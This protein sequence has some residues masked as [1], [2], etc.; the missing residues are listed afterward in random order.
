MN[1]AKSP[2]RTL[3]LLR[4][5]KSSW[6]DPALTD[7]ERPLNKRGRRDA[8]AMAHRIVEH[9][10]TLT[11]IFASP[12]RRSRETLTRILLTLPAQD[13]SITVDQAFYTF[14]CDALVNAIR[15]FDDNLQD[16]MIIGHN[17]ALEEAITWMTG[18]TLSCF[19]T[20]AC[21]QLT[22]TLSSWKKLQPGCADLMWLLTPEKSLTV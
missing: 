18:T 12:A 19:P 7:I 2:L 1:K 22:L 4:H 20:T 5:A 10:A 9:G 17:P 11:T 13:T 15:S 14:E 6:K 16:V 3:T 21:A 8:R